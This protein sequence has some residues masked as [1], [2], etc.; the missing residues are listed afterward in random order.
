MTLPL[1]TQAIHIETN[2][3]LMAQGPIHIKTGHQGVI[4]TLQ[5]RIIYYPYCARQ[6]TNDPL[7]HRGTVKMPVHRECGAV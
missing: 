7:M 4:N 1:N 3:Q 5:L 2:H 6:V